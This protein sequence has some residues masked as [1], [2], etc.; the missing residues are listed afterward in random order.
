LETPQPKVESG[1]ALAVTDGF[2]PSRGPEASPLQPIPMRREIASAYPGDATL[3]ALFFDRAEHTP[4]AIAIIDEQRELSYAQ[5]ALRVNSLAHAL[6][7]FGAG[8]NRRIGIC[9][10]RSTDMV[11]TLLAVLATGAA[12]VPL[13]PSYPA[14]RLSFMAND[15]NL[16]LV[17]TQRS[18]ADTLPVTAVPVMM[19]DELDLSAVD[20]ASSWPASP[21]DL[22]Y[23]IYT[24]GS[25]GRP[26]GVEIRHRSVVNLLFAMQRLLGV[27]AADRVLTLANISFDMSVPELF[28][29][30]IAGASMVVVS[31][32]EVAEPRGLLARWRQSGATVMQATP[33]MWR[34]LIRA[35]W[36]GSRGLKLVCGGDAV[37]AELGQQLLARAGRFWN[38]YGPTEATVWSTAHE[39]TRI[40]GTR[41]PIGRPLANTHL[42]ILDQQHR[43]V[44]I[45]DI[46]ELYIG[47]VGVARGY[48]GRPDLT[49][50]RFFDDPFAGDCA[51][52]M[53][54]TGDLAS[55]LP[56]GSIEFRGRVDDQIKIRG[57]RIELGE[58]EAVLAESPGVREAAVVARPGMSVDCQ[59]IAFVTGTDARDRGA[60]RQSLRARLPRYMVPARIIGVDSLPL[61]PNGKI[62][63]QRLLEVIPEKI[64]RTAAYQPASDP[65]EAKLVELF[66]NLLAHSPIGIDDEFFEFGGDSLLALNL[67]E[68]VRE[69]FGRVIQVNALY[70]HGSTVAALARMLRDPPSPRGADLGTI[71]NSEDVG[72]LGEPIAVKHPVD[73]AEA[74]FGSEYLLIRNDKTEKVAAITRQSI[75]EPV[76]EVPDFAGFLAAL[77]DEIHG[78]NAIVALGESTTAN[79][80]NW[81]YQLA[82]DP[83]FRRSETV[84]LNLADW[85]VGV[86]F[87]IERLEFILDWLRRRGASKLAVVL[88]GGF[89]EGHIV[90]E[91]RKKF[92]KGKRSVLYRSLDYQF[93]KHKFGGELRR[94]QYELPADGGTGFQWFVKLILATIGVLDQICLA[95]DSAFVAVLQPLSYADVAPG[96]HRELR[97][98]Y[99]DER[100]RGAYEEWRHERKYT[101]DVFFTNPEEEFRPFYNALAEAWRQAGRRRHGVYVDCSTL[102]RDVVDPCFELDGIHY[103]YAGT[104]LITKT[105][106][107]HLPKTFRK[108]RQA[109][110]PAIG[111][112]RS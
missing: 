8:P 11:A 85:A 97:R 34:L 68:F 82:A 93:K 51:G 87:H 23:V 99:E 94:L 62:D 110:R 54:R 75:A 38:F 95:A 42:Y 26:K 60:L 44:P 52:R 14:D 13:D 46:G 25:T 10:E 5:L 106:L 35:G 50:E 15:A 70:D 96:Y 63:R 55:F 86:S 79:F 24:S 73:Q 31:R 47:G 98:R 12:Y 71:K 3:H 65:I 1:P 83:G 76:R 56:D 101:P 43:P 53:Y 49:A 6:S 57:L 81:P 74:Y 30:L 18:L 111:G 72:A 104:S 102:F 103:D 4:D 66:E 59:L 33:V 19:I 16:T 112:I 58:I 90:H 89:V 88:L 100:F 78:K 61:T 69:S 91:A 105:I 109:G 28:L 22:A 107:A 2:Q 27:T 40:E 7:H 39:V 41:V 9:L 84:V 48:L 77:S 20:A 67:L 21:D 32:A 37:D 17:I 92:L 29:A 64:E 45:G 80:N 36:A 108:G